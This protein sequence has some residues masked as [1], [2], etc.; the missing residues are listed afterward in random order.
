M[1]SRVMETVKHFKEALPL[2]RQ[3]SN[4][5]ENLEEAFNA[6]NSTAEERS[7]VCH[8]FK[9]AGSQFDT[10]AWQ[11]ER[12]FLPVKAEGILRK[13]LSG[14]Y[15]IEGTDIELTCGSYVEALLPYYSGEDSD[16]QAWVPTSIEY[17]GD[18]YFAARTKAILDG[19]TVRIR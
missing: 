3:L 10:A 13:N 4:D 16:I 19:V 6:E 11:T 5:L 9:I 7:Y 18:Y 14:R 12:M 1:K 17:D 15:E 8:L 2:L